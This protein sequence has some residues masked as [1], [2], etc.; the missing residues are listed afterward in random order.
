MV[1]I[2]TLW[3]HT[4]PVTCLSYAADMEVVLSGGANGLLC[5]HTVRKGYFIRSIKNLM[6]NA[7]HHVLNTSAG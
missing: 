2:R 7:V 1:Y 3:G 5:L 6:G 4:S